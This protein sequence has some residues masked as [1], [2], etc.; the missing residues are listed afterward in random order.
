M[1]N[2]SR[3]MVKYAPYQSLVEQGKALS[4]MRYDK[5]RTPKRLL[6]SD[7]A[8]EI[9]ELLIHYQSEPVVVVFWRNGFFYEER[10]IIQRIDAQRK[11]IQIN[12]MFV[13]FQ[14]FQSIKRI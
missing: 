6:S 1:S 14:E 13:Q 12:G 4:K 7:A 8:E 5:Q 3:G 10:G 9:N 2:E 11:R